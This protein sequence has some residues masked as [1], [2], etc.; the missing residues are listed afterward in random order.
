MIQLVH[1]TI[2]KTEIKAVVKTL[3]SR[4]L[5]RGNV[6]RDLENILQKKFNSS[7]AIVVSNGTAALFTALLACGLSKGDEVI[8]TT[9]SFIATVNSILLSGAKPVFVD[10]DKNTFNIDVSKIEDKITKKTKAILVVDLYGYPAEY[11]ILRKLADK[12]K[13]ILISDSCQ[14]IGSQ[15]KNKFINHF[16]DLTILSFFN[17]KNLSSGEGGVL[18][19]NQKS[20]ADRVNLLINHGQKRGEKYNFLEP[21]WNFRPTDI[22]SSIIKTQMKRL[23]FITLKR[24]ANAIFLI[25]NLSSIEG[26]VCPQLRL[27]VIHSFSRFTI[28]ITDK[29]SLSRDEFKKYLNRNGIETE[30]AYPKALYDYSYLKKYKQGNFLITENVINQVLSIPIHQNLT[31]KDLNYIV[32]V[33][34]KVKKDKL[35]NSQKVRN[36]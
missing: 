13:L 9:F 31:K 16:T 30:I 25:N 4:K 10:I 27:D 8:T 6:T 23:D 21:G 3:L 5:E 15:Y 22:Q 2:G 34:K 36:L 24:N 33:I 20:I 32:T 11:E 28:K 26:I 12:Y 7:Y 1:P 35:N 17:S 19:T 14:A 29:F 18:L